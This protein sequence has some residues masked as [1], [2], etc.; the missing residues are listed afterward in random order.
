M[1]GASLDSQVSVLV[2]R[3]ILGLVVALA[4]LVRLTSIFWKVDVAVSTQQ[5][6]L[7]FFYFANVVNIGL[8]LLYH[9][10]HQIARAPNYFI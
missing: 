1:L 8:G 4:F 5:R 10:R 2:K 7:R 3:S 9:Y 6:P